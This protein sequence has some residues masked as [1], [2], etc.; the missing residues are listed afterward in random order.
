LESCARFHTQIASERG[1]LTGCKTI[2]QLEA[3]LQTVIEQRNHCEAYTPVRGACGG[4]SVMA[5]QKWQA[6]PEDI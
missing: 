6:K 2:A 5:K 4:Y 3:E 1:E